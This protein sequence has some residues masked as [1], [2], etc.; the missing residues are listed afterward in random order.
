MKLALVVPGGVDRSGEDRV[1][2]ALLALVR[3]LAA[4]HELHVFALAQEPVPGSWTLEGAVI[5][6]IGNAR[7]I[8]RTVAAIRREHRRAPF[9]LV[10][11]IWSGFSG[12]SAVA[13]AKLMRVPACVHVAG[14][15]LAALPV[16][17]YG[18]QLRWH[19]R[20]LERF[21]LRNARRVTA[22][23]EP[24][25]AM[26][27]RFG[28]RAQRLP[29]GVDLQSWPPLPPRRRVAGTAARLVHVASLNRV[30]DQTT[31]LEAARRLVERG[32]DFHLDVIGEDT[33]G[34]AV[35][36]LAVRLGLAQ[37]VTFHGVLRQGAMRPIVE[38]AV[39]NVISSLHEAGPLVVLEAAV[40]GVPTVGTRVGHIAE[41][42]GAAAIAVSPGDAAALAAG[43]EALLG[44]ESR[45]QQLAL[46]AQA[47]A[48]TEDAD[49]TAARFLAM[50]DELTH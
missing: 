49:Y 34:G 47:R 2:P 35:Q 40:A 32:L 16:I 29:L 10:Q 1:I 6:N 38:R 4:A 44:D 23:S 36:A 46:A 39:L 26:I 21:T 9:A 48:M 20:V 33:L 18:G 22:A 12:V 28:G 3:R 11:A 14:G 41:W 5:H 37:H 31:L 25:I 43:I 30:K 8:G 50:Y 42:D 19:W 13:A 27:E 24:V 45:R 15:E 17:G 7:A